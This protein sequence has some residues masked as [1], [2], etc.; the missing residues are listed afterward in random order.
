[1]TEE[2]L[3]HYGVLGM[4]W[5][6]GKKATDKD[7]QKAR[8]RLK[9]QSKAYRKEYKKYDRAAEGS[10]RKQALETKLRR[11][12]Q[13]YMKDP[14]RVVAARMMRGEKFGTAYAAVMASVTT[15]GFGT[16]VNAAIA[17]GTIATT[18]AI[19]RRIEYKQDRGDYNKIDKRQPVSKKIG[20]QTG[21]TLLVNGAAAAPGLA[22]LIGPMASLTITQKAASNRAAAKA[23]ASAPKA[24]ATA[25]EKLKYVKPGRGGTFKITTM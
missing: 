13:N 7:I 20:F 23:A 14:D 18:S 16:P 9:A 19:S 22:G 25:A 3:L 17:G 1:M 12:E 21:R 6:Q 2:E 15:G 8:K 4:K 11:L 24:I 10:V 5:G